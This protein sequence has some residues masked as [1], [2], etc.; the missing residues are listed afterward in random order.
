MRKLNAVISP[1]ILV[2]F[3][4]HGVLGAFNLMGTGSVTTKVLAQTMLGLIAVHTLIGCILTGQTLHILRKSGAGYFRDNLLFWA[5]R[6]SGFLIMALI[7]FHVTAFSGVS[8]DNYRLPLFDTFRLITQIFL[9]VSVA[10]HVITNAKPM[11]ISFGI[12][13][14]KPRV[15]DILFWMSALMLFMAAAFIVYYLRWR[16]V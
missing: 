5:R 16:A 8:A 1:I 10:F 7:F 13:K 2:L 12:K 15:G 9:V 4:V 3:I 6:I 11:L 14:L